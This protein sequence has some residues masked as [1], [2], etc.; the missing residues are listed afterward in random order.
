MIAIQ[1]HTFVFLQ[2]NTKTANTDR[3]TN[4]QRATDSN[5][6]SSPGVGSGSLSLMSRVKKKVEKKKNSTRP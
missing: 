3:L 5:T 6:V 4:R 1:I 2:C